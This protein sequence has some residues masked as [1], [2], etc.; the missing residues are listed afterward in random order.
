MN[1][2]IGIIELEYESLHNEDKITA[3]GLTAAELA[4][5]LGNDDGDFDQLMA[6]ADEAP[7]EKAVNSDLEEEGEDFINISRLKSKYLP[8]D[9]ED[10]DDEKLKREMQPATEQQPSKDILK[11]EKLRV[12]MPPTQKPFQPGSMPPN[13]RERFMVWN[14]IGAVIQFTEDCETEGQSSSIEVEFHDVSMHHSVHIDNSSAGYSMADLSSTAIMLASPGLHDPDLIYQDAEQESVDC[15]QI[16]LR[17]IELAGFSDEDNL[18]RTGADGADWLVELP[19]GEACLAICLI[20]SSKNRGFAAC[21]TSKNILRFFVQ[22]DASILRE[23]MRLKLIQISQATLPPVSLPGKSVLTMAS[24][25]SKPILGAVCSSYS[26]FELMWRVFHLSSSGSTWLQGWQPL[27][28]SPADPETQ[29]PTRLLWFGFSDLGNVYTHDSCGVVRR[30][31]HQKG[32]DLHW[33]SVGDTKALVKTANQRHD[34]YFLVSVIEHP[35]SLL[36]A[37]ADVPEGADRCTKLEHDPLEGPQMQV[38]YCKSSAYPRICPK[39]LVHH[40]PLR[41]STCNLLSCD[42]ADL[43]ENYLRC[44]MAVN[45]PVWDTVPSIDQPT[46]EMHNNLLTGWISKEKKILLRMFALAAKLD[47]EWAS[48]HVANLMPDTETIQLAIRYAARLQRPQLVEKLAALALAKQEQSEE[49]ELEDEDD[50]QEQALEDEIQASESTEEDLD[51]DNSTQA[52]QTKETR[53]TK[54]PAKK[55]KNVSTKT[56]KINFK[57]NGNSNEKAE[58]PNFETWFEKKRE[59]MEEEF[60]ELSAEEL[61]EEARKLYKEEMNSSKENVKPRKRLNPDLASHQETESKR[62]LTMDVAQSTSKK[63]SAFTFQT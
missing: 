31:W 19:P 12:E 10:K 9:D 35:E 3:G 25:P 59:A 4:D 51:E 58:A 29:K 62:R 20:A 43:E 63:L 54:K 41:M 57:T 13:F 36:P 8:S 7:K 42:Q 2:F 38:I 53:V 61:F 47:S 44:Q 45:W 34:R 5:F 50:E 49:S 40:L 26:A 22:P 46:S 18:A 1:G 11:A 56:N 15:A 32:R 6:I 33:A 55:T 16:C 39:P 21:A 14:R 30:L 37:G 17:P 27:P 23:S 52:D 24:H 28:V 48:L 60:T